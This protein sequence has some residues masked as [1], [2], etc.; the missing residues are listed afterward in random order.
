MRVL[1]IITVRSDSSV[2]AL[3]RTRCGS[4]FRGSIGWK[5]RMGA[6]Q[7]SLLRGVGISERPGEQGL[8]VGPD[9]ARE[10]G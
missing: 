5:S 6:A 7:R 10:I 4:G 8:P 2:L 3:V 9:S 1:F